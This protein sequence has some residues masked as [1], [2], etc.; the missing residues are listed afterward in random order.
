[1]IVVIADGGV[2]FLR[3]ENSI[4]IPEMAICLSC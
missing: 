2:Y 4:L 1:V 3:V